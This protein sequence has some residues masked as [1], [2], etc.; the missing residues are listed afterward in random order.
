MTSRDGRL[1]RQLFT[2]FLAVAL[3]P[4]LVSGLLSTT[5]ISQLAERLQRE[6]LNH[7]TKQVSHQ[8]L[9]RLLLARAELEAVRQTGRPPAQLPRAFARLSSTH[10]SLA[11]TW[12][13]A[14]Q[15][16]APRTGPGTSPIAHV[17]LV[18]ARPDGNSQV[19]MALGNPEQP[20]LIGEVDAH[21]LWEP[22]ALEED[23]GRW[24]VEDHAHHPL[25]DNPG[26]VNAVTSESRLFLDAELG[27][28]EWTFRQSTALAP[29]NWQGMSLPVWLTLIGA[30]TLLGIA[31]ISHVQIRRTLAPLAQL[32]ADTRRLADGGHTSVVQVNDH[33]EIGDLAD[34][35][36]DMAARIREQ[37][38]A[39]NGLAAVD[40]GILAGKSPHELAQE[41][42]T[43]LS[44]YYPGV[45][46]MTSWVEGGNTLLHMLG[47]ASSN[48]LH[49]QA[50][51]VA[52]TPEQWRRYV[53]SPM[54]DEDGQGLV[55]PHPWLAFAQEQL[56]PHCRSFPV[57]DGDKIIG[58][59]TV[60]TGDIQTTPNW[61]HLEGLRDRLSVAF[62]TRRREQE[63]AYRAVHDGLTGLAN[64]YGLHDHLDHQLN[65]LGN[66]H[67]AVLFVDLDHFKDVNDSLG[68]EAGDELLCL[69]SERLQSCLE[70]GAL[71]ARRGG[72]EFVLVQP[73]ADEAHAIQ[74]AAQAV[75]L[76]AAPFNVRGRSLV[77]GGSVGVA[78]APQHGRS[79][80]E[81]LRCADVAMY[82]AK[83][84]GRGCHALYAQDLD[85]QSQ[86]RVRL[87]AELRQA[88]IHHELRAHYQPRVSSQD[89]QVYSAEALVR[90]QHPTRGLLLPGHFIPLAEE[91]HLIEDIGLWMLDAA[92]QQMADWRAQGVPMARVSVN[93]SPR[94]LATGQ[95][96]EQVQAALQRH[97]L[98]A[99][100]LELEVTESLLVGDARQACQQLAALRSL[101]V[102]IALDDFGTGYSSLAIL[103]Q[104]PVDIMKVDRAFVKDL[105][106]D[107]GAL[108]VTQAIVGMAQSLG[109]NIVAEGME[110]A[111][112]ARILIKL[113]CHELQGFYFSR[114][115]T[116]ETLT[117]AMQHPYTL[118]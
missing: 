37:F 89:G 2:L 13:E 69:A 39:L 67:L 81:L 115:V 40:R 58:R 45:R 83:A 3:V 1:T 76:L 24:H 55:P 116:S 107:E 92:C 95:L 99:T 61:Q 100:S 19:L 8:V 15:A 90:W 27:A 28:G 108:A 110:T 31:F 56:W 52:L 70:P 75:T 36:N 93:V 22:V 48:D 9:D 17:R 54:R 29:A 82:Q 103:R 96:V 14:E 43:H 12:Q 41:V 111:E 53:Q 60:C 32:T 25:R 63:L 34:A 101:G 73:G 87:Q 11:Q 79:R 26:P 20:D 18:H 21:F 44:H 84:H 4:L 51:Q 91:S 5:A 104:L 57:Q 74:L 71:L 80:A 46:M 33:N 42:L 114:P 23:N 102:M 86:A 49:W 47:R 113:G 109:L 117:Q 65:Q 35:F 77:L 88:L 64:R 85:A 62:A 38:R 98:P 97:Q 16:P 78:V 106:Q 10:P 68:H 112:Q 72:D 6:H 105:D 50:R 66:G 118:P 94:Q 59:I 7:T 30:L